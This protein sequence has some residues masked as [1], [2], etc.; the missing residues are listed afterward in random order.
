MEADVS[1]SAHRNA[2]K[3]SDAACEASAAA[4][5]SRYANA[6]SRS[7]DNL[8]KSIPDSIVLARQARDGGHGTA[9]Q[10]QPLTG[11]QSPEPR[12]ARGAILHPKAHHYLHPQKSFQSKATAR[13]GRRGRKAR[14]GRSGS[15]ACLV[16]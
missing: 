15:A 11:F 13:E 4:E 2:S 16:A 3:R 7:P 9:G 8:G 6:C 5:R 1:D 10:A 14:Q 12:L